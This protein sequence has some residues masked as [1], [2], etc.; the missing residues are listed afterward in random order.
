MSQYNG[1]Y[2]DENG[3]PVKGAY[4]YVFTSEGAAASIT[5][6][7]DNP[8]SHPLIT[9][10]DGNFSYRAADG[11]Y[12]HQIWV[13]K[14]RVL[15][16]NEVLLG[17]SYRDQAQTAAAAASAGLGAKPAAN[18]GAGLA[19]TAL[20]ETFWVDNGNGTG[21]VY[22]HD[23]GPVATEIGKFVK[24]QTAP[25]AA[26]LIA[27]GIP[28]LATLLQSG[29]S[30]MVG[31]IHGLANAAIRTAEAKLRETVSVKDYEGL[32]GDGVANDTAAFQALLDDWGG[33]AIYVP[34]GVTIKL[35]DTV[36]MSVANTKLFG[37][38][39]IITTAALAQKM[40]IKVT[41]DDCEFDGLTFDNVT[42]SQSQTGPAGFGVDFYAHRGMVRFCTF[43]R[44]QHS[45]CDSAFG[46]WYGTR[47]LYNSFLECIGA[48]D[49]P[50]DPIS[51][52]GEDRGD[53]ATIWAAGAMVIGNFAQPANGQD[54]RIAFHTEGLDE[55]ADDTSGPDNAAMTIIALNRAVPSEDG[56]G[57]FR[58]LAMA[59]NVKRVLIFGNEGRGF[60][61]WGCGLLGSA[62]YSIM[63]H[64]IIVSD[65]DP[66]DESGEAWGPQRALYM[67]YGGSTATNI[68]SRVTSNMGLAL[69]AS[70]HGIFLQGV[71]GLFRAAVV[72]D[73]SI[74]ASVDMGNYIGLHASDTP[75]DVTLRDNDVIGDWLHSIYAG[76]VANIVVDGGRYDGAD[77]FAINIATAT[78][79]KI[80]GDPEIL[81]AAFG[82]QV[83]S[84]VAEVIGAQFDNVGGSEIVFVSAGSPWVDRCYDRDGSGAISIFGGGTVFHGV[85]TGFVTDSRVAATEITSI[86]SR[87]NT[88]GK[89]AGKQLV[90]VNGVLWVATGAGANSNW[91]KVEDGTTVTPA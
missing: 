14:R 82:I 56:T 57:R 35:D 31:F 18:T 9:D 24:D 27:G 53:A 23:A 13:G 62:A 89:H 28:T 34:E 3:R 74:V 29:G 87:S 52:Y 70:C 38:G 16:E 33:K 65:V 58:R 41:G 72:N 39:R 61:W 80:K 30:A 75:G 54:C 17:P 15:I 60:T 91:K 7:N 43:Y 1:N 44:F 45:V 11:Y 88:W 10:E 47:I 86:A 46:E 26:P 63:S 40:A 69:T 78:K 81:N 36:E 59:E 68:G 64:N 50:D 76:G 8:I 4:V 71:T 42:A 51:T 85:N 90:D 19:A 37:P 2:T 73:N 84:P 6:T 49:G 66:D 5:D 21:T 77:N 12:R 20:G 25:A 55:F 67:V 32:V 48:G 83:Q 22:R 79:A